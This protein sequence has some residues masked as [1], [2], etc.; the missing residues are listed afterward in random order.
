MTKNKSKACGKTEGYGKSGDLLHER[1]IAVAGYI[2]ENNATVRQTAKE[3]GI[4]KSTVHKA[5]TDRLTAINPALAK[6]VRSV[7]D[8]NKSERH[9]RGGLAT[10]EKYLHQHTT[11]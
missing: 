11:G 4:S 6:Q 1:V 2:V 10:R 9:I 5:V 7:L 8:V 3:F